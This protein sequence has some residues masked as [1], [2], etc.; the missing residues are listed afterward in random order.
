MTKIETSPSEQ[1]TSNQNRNRWPNF[2]RWPASTAPD[3]FHQRCLRRAISPSVPPPK[4]TACFETKSYPFFTDPNPD[5]PSLMSQKW[6][7]KKNNQNA[8]SSTKTLGIFR[9]DQREPPTRIVMIICLLLQQGLGIPQILPFMVFK[10]K[11]EFSC[12]S[13]CQRI[14]SSETIL[15]WSMVWHR[16]SAATS[17]A[18][19]YVLPLLPWSFPPYE[20]PWKNDGKNT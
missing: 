2:H 3:V 8:L 14:L 20:W 18:P 1:T 13:R 15:C 5:E 11:K 12:H 10:K 9:I 17:V 7:P 6:F 4:K 19:L 16:P